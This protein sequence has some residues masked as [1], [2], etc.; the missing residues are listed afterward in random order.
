MRLTH[1][2]NDNFDRYLPNYKN[3]R[4]Q[5]NNKL[6]QVEDIEERIPLLDIEKILDASNVFVSL[7]PTAGDISNSFIILLEIEK[8]TSKGLK[9]SMPNNYDVGFLPFD[10]YKKYWALTKNEL[11]K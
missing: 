1:K 11:E 4:E 5:I 8:V 6:G 7:V 3:T 9:L 10:G 2:T